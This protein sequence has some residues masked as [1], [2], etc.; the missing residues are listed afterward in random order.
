M[1]RLVVWYCF[2]V[3]LLVILAAVATKAQ[4]CAGGYSTATLDSCHMDS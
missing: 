1:K 4:A 3:V 2:L